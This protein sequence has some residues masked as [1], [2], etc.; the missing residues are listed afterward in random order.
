MQYHAALLDN[1]NTGAR[2]VRPE[3][4]SGG[5]MEAVSTLSFPAAGRPKAESAARFPP[6]C[7]EGRLGRSPSGVGGAGV[8]HGGGKRSIVPAP[9]LD[10]QAPEIDPAPPTPTPPHKG[11]GNARPPGAPGTTV[12]SA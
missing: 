6:P 7:G 9:A 1:T 12:G 4:H 8:E 11:E 3:G 5:V 10:T 2:P